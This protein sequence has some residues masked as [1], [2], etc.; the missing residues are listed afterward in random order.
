[1]NQERVDI[2]LHYHSATGVRR[3]R[4]F[5]SLENA[6]NYASGFG[7]RFR[8]VCSDFAVERDG[9]TLRTEGCTFRELTEN[10]P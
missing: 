3:S 1:M 10:N 5:T 2:R 7:E 4:L 6:R 8:E 9:G